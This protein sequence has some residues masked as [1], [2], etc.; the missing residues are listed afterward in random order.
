MKILETKLHKN[1]IKQWTDLEKFQS[2]E[3]INKSWSDAFTFKQENKGENQIGLR[4][5]QLGA[6]HRSLSHWSYSEEI[7]T[8]V[9][10]TGT[11]K[12]ETMLSLLV[13]NRCRK[14]LVIV[15]TNALREQISDKFITFGILKKLEALRESALL[16][17]VGVLKTR[18]KNTNEASEFFEKCNV[19]VATANI[20]A[21][22]SDDIFRRFYRPALTYFY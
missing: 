4:H 19:V 5:P 17:V 3:E 14:L 21:G 22:V 16:P 13:L 10:P 2:P 15:P 8:I 12:T 11:G 1:F 6:I 18:F 20:L 7:A 9:M